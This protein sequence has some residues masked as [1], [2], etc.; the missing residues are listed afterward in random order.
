MLVYLTA[1]L[2][3]ATAAVV[4]P[5]AGLAVGYMQLY[6]SSR[7]KDMRISM[8]KD[9]EEFIK[10]LNG[11]YVRKESCVLLHGNLIDRVEKLEGIADRNSGRDHHT[12][13]PEGDAV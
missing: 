5:V 6:V 4:V 7:L 12:H 2:V 10:G 3:G 8:G 9:R 13:R 1:E 11:T